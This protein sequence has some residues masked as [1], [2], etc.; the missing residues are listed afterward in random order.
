MSEEEFLGGDGLLVFPLR[1]NILPDGFSGATFAI[2]QG[3]DRIGDHDDG[4]LP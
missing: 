1:R 2:F 4:L 3:E